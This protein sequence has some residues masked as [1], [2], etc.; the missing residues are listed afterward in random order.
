MKKITMLQDEAYEKIYEMVEEGKFEEGK[1]YSVNS[2]ANNLGMSKTPI[3]DAMQRLS[4]DGIIEILPSRGF[5]LAELS[6]QDI[7]DIYQIRCALEGYACFIL[8]KEYGKNEEFAILQDIKENL[9]LQKKSVADGISAEDF[10]KIDMEFHK[11][12]ISAM[13]SQRIN[14][15]ENEIRQQMRIFSLH[16]LVRKGLLDV[17]VK[18]HQAIYDAIIEKNPHRAAYMLY[19]HLST[20]KESYDDMD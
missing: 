5:R 1:I 6:K 8:T 20:M 10:Y 18:E 3:R 15:I 2:L 13:H 9:E 14:N 16:S 11:L 17:T 12:L 7:E 19:S 4:S